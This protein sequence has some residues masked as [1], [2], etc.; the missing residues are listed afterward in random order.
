MT[1]FVAC[2]LAAIVALSYAPPLRASERVSPNDTARFLAGLHPS[3]DSPLSALTKSAVWQRHAA[4]F[5]TLFE[6]KNRDS[7]NKIRVFAAKEVPHADRPLL[8][9]FSGPDFLYANAFFGD[10]PVYVLSG[11]EPAGDIPKIEDLDSRAVEFTLHNTER[12]LNSVLDLSFFQTNDMRRELSAGPVFGTLPILYIFLARAGKTISEAE[13]IVL[14]QDGGIKKATPEGQAGSGDISQEGMRGLRIV[15]S[16]KNHSQQTLYYFSGDISNAGLRKSGLLKFCESLG[17]AN[18]LLKSASYLLHRDRYADL[19]DFILKQ[20]AL[21]AQDDS[22]IP[23]SSF[24]PSK[25][26]LQ[27]F[28]NYV[29]PI[30][31]FRNRYQ[32]SLAHLFQARERKGLD[33]GVG[34][35][36]RR[37]RSNLLLAVQKPAIL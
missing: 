8:Y 12:S 6:L 35:Q 36:W 28:G 17:Q 31:L 5:D 15:F 34:Y 13:T 10:A 2:V 21:I 20:S 11:L 18:A 29:G 7:L 33:F 3:P 19:R 23:I 32:A 1:K 30:P 9:F 22:G 14:D 25:S 37:N 4:R 24:D 26:D 27:P 16:D